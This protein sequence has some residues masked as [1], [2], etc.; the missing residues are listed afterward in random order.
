MAGLA[1]LLFGYVWNNFQSRERLKAEIILLRH[2]LTGFS[3]AM[4][5]DF[6]VLRKVM[7]PASES[8]A[9]SIKNTVY[10][11]TDCPVDR[12]L[13]RAVA[14]MPSRRANVHEKLQRSGQSITANYRYCVPLVV[15]LVTAAQYGWPRRLPSKEVNSENYFVNRPFT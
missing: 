6:W 1:N 10:R 8:R 5:S 7:L 15:S 11:Q 12:R 4:P 2:Q 9:A 3:S 13:R 14:T